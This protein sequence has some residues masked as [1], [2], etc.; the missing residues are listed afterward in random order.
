MAVSEETV[1][2]FRQNLPNFYMNMNFYGIFPDG[3]KV[4]L[5]EVPD[6]MRANP[7]LRPLKMMGDR[8]VAAR[9][10]LVVEMTTPAADGTESLYCRQAFYLST[11]TSSDFPSTWLPFDGLV[12]GVPVAMVGNILLPPLYPRLG[13]PPP[14]GAVMQD[15]VW[16]NKNEFLA[17][18]Q[19]DFDIRIDPEETLAV[20]RLYRGGFLPEPAD[21]RVG[22]FSHVIASYM[23]GGNRWGGK[24]GPDNVL[25]Y[26]Q[27]AREIEPGDYVNIHLLND[28]LRAP[29][30]L[31]PAFTL[32]RDT[33][34]LIPFATSQEINAYIER[35]DAISYMNGF[36]GL[37]I[38]IP[39]PSELAITARYRD[40]TISLPL[41]YLVHNLRNILHKVFM[42]WKTGRIAGDAATIAA[43]AGDEL[44]RNVTMIEGGSKGKWNIL[45]HIDRIVFTINPAQE[46][47][48]GGRRKKRKTVKRKVRK[49][50]S[51]RKRI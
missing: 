27:G 45:E 20:R 8:D 32:L 30:P 49:G 33:P 19:N 44:Q 31:D 11:G 16:V 24:R 41:Y 10:V 35:F 2:A 29:R 5:N 34:D 18:T 36:V 26:M 7:A 42:A 14:E 1:M 12:Y 40:T 22:P 17:D 43:V 21:D 13:P 39:K 4:R 38:A 46:G 37:G 51:Y 50:K 9:L 28:A 25:P 6:Q 47:V 48:R 3:T 23:L 15:Q